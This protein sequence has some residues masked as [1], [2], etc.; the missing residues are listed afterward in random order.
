LI[1]LK[2]NLIKCNVLS[3]NLL[4]PFSIFNDLNKTFYLQHLPC[5]FF[6]SLHKIEKDL[7][8]FM[9]TKV[10]QC[11]NSEHRGV[12]TG[13]ENCLKFYKDSKISENSSKIHELFWNLWE[14]LNKSK[15]YE[16][17]SNFYHNSRKSMDNSRK[18][19]ENSSA[20]VDH[21]ARYSRTRYTALITKHNPISKRDRVMFIRYYL[22]EAN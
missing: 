3:K 1:N 10:M 20:I 4:V 17:F 19:M 22:K 2:K 18:S 13:L 11:K 12:D 15:I 16:K 8:K 9:K 14:F 7:I 6:I 5:F 21:Q